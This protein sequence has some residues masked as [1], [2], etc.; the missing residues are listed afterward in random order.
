[1]S[2]RKL[3]A[4]GVFSLALP[5]AAQALPCAGFTDVDDSSTFCPNVEWM[6]NR[7]ITLGCSAGLYCPNDA[8]LRLSMSAFM[9]RLGTTLTPQVVLQEG[10]YAATDL[11]TA[12]VV[13][14]TAP[15]AITGYPRSANARGNVLLRADGSFSANLN[16]VVSTD[17][18]TTWTPMT[19]NDS[20]FHALGSYGDFV[21][22][23]AFTGLVD[24]NVGGTYRF[25]LQ[26]ERAAGSAGGQI[27]DGS[28]QVAVELRS[29]NGATTPI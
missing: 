27:Q 19:V 4:F 28:C 6:K 2:L 9:N 8:V 21:T 1:M 10:G 7:A 24:L 20:G 13:C 11:D 16:L 17:N 25:G 15:V 22:G 23:Q 14:Q 5:T 29:R 26:M 18:G 12:P 3:I